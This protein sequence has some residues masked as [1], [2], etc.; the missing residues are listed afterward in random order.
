MTEQQQSVQKSKAEETQKNSPNKGLLLKSVREE[1]GISLETV[2][3]ATKVPLDVLRAIEEGYTVRTLSEFYYRSFV[4]IYANYLDID[5][6][7]VIDNYKKEELPKHIE[8]EPVSDFDVKEWVSKVL[9]PERKKQLA[10]G[11]GIIAVLFLLF[12]VISFFVS[13][14][15]VKSS[16]REVVQQVIIDADQTLQQNVEPIQEDI[17]TSSAPKSEIFPPTAIQPEVTEVQ[18]P[19]YDVVLT[20]RAPKKSWLRVKVDD[21]VV[22]QSTLRSGAVETWNAHEKIEI[23]GRN[24]SQLEFELNGKMIG[25]LGRANRRAKGLTVT[26]NGL[27]VTK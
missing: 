5:V 22:F 25:T 23:I 16:K 27:S 14:K 4:K 21:V 2:H 1:K 15:S 3:E 20:V 17:A 13:R 8:D 10:M 11:A 19:E 26:K 6:T 18:N 9:T 7:K 24:I 12:T